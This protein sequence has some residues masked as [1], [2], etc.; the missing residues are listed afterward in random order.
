[1][2]SLASMRYAVDWHGS[3]RL[4]G[5]AVSRSRQADG[6]L[7]RLELCVQS[8]VCMIVKRL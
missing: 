5:R 1:M 4:A 2:T 3:Y 7:M 8:H 6:P